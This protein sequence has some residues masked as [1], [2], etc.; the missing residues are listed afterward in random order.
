MENEDDEAKRMRSVA[1]QNAA[2]IL[3][4]RQRAERELLEA[5]EALE[6]RTEELAL[7]LAMVRATLESTT[8]AILV[9]NASGEGVDGGLS[10]NSVTVNIRHWLYICA[11]CPISFLSR[12]M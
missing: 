5:K 4:A 11:H 12:F 10:V 3:L 1:L 7:S 8:D 2:A 6:R 9:T